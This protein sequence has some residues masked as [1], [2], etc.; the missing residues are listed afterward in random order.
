MA[1]AKQKEMAS[2]KKEEEALSKEVQQATNN[3][4]RLKAEL[5]ELVKAR[6]A[7]AEQEQRNLEEQQAK[8]DMFK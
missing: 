8:A 3:S 4:I 6:R 2:L 1:Y 7:T 5:E